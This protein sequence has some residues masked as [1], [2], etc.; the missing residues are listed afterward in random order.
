MPK[1]S[2]G[3]ALCSSGPKPKIRYK[4]KIAAMLALAKITQQDKAGRP[5]TESRFYRCPHC[6]GYHLTSKRRSSRT[7][8]SSDRNS[9]PLA[10]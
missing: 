2:G 5:A 7:G 10:L 6:R 3:R 4:D 1:T 9:P 8:K